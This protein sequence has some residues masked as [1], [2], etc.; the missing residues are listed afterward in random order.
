MARWWLTP[1]E[2]VTSKFPKR[3]FGSEK[4]PL[5]MSWFWSLSEGFLLAGKDIKSFQEIPMWQGRAWALSQAQNHGLEVPK[6]ILR[7]VD[8]PVLATV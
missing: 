6:E 1:Q 7:L 4:D 8:V 2:Q 5:V 3:L